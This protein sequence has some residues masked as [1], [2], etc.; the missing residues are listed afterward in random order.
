MVSVAIILY[1]VYQIY[2]VMV[3]VPVK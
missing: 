3:L 2:N 1:F